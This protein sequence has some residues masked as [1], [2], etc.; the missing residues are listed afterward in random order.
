MKRESAVITV[1]LSLVFVLLIS[2]TGV[3]LESASVQT[4]KNI[5]KTQTNLALESVFAE[6]DPDLQEKYHLF[7][8]DGGRGG[9]ED[10]EETMLSR[11]Q[12]YR[13]DVQ[14]AVLGK[15]QYLSDDDG[16]PFY[17]QVLVYMSQKSAVTGIAGLA[18][19]AGI[20]KGFEQEEAGKLDV[21]EELISGFAGEL[22]QTEAVGGAVEMFSYFAGIIGHSALE[23]VMPQGIHVSDASTQADETVS[24]RTRLTGYGTF[25]QKYD[26]PPLSGG[27][28]DTYLLEV[29]GKATDEQKDTGLSYEIEYILAGKPTDR[30]NLE[31]VT[32]RLLM[33]RTASNLRFLK[34]SAAKQA[35]ITETAAFLATVLLIPE[36]EPALQEA[37]T[38]IWAYAEAMMDVKALLSGKKVPLTKDETSWTLSLGGLMSYERS[39]AEGWESKE[40]EDG[41]TYAEYLRMLLALGKREDKCM[42]ALDLI[43]INLSEGREHA[44]KADHAIC[45]VQIDSSC[46]LP[47]SIRYSFTTAFGYR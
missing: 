21:Q 12:F 17:E 8:V 24:Q 43:E 25:S 3:L 26:I 18:E 39:H 11:L 28:F 32:G 9:S 42:R 2:F 45:R 33:V 27:L 14:D 31:D 36:G 23:M 34:E 6:Y 7:A 19:K 20:I 5:A 16:M 41:W 37:I 29:M 44:F 35:E 47:R 4:A 30:E 22:A 13:A 40:T 38:F 1:Y 15:V 46:A 10:P